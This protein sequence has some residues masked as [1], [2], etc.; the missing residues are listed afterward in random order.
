LIAFVSVDPCKELLMTDAEFPET[1]AGGAV[2]RFVGKVK[3]A[4]GA[5]VGNEDLQ[6]EG[7]LQQACWRADRHDR[8]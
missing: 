8:S 7:N 6:R 5:L 2:G 1:T 4:A 3:S